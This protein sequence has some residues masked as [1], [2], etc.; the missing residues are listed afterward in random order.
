[1]SSGALG[2]AQSA[3]G[4][5]QRRQEPF[6]IASLSPDTTIAGEPVEVVLSSFFLF[7][8]VPRKVDGRVLGGDVSAECFRAG[9]RREAA[10]DPNAGPTG[11]ET[12]KVSWPQRWR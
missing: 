2:S 9:E 5:A 8:R 3:L 6:G 10:S 4:C 12:E 1:M 11:G 7:R